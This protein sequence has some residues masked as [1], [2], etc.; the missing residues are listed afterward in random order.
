[1]KADIERLDGCQ[2]VLDIEVDA[3][4]MGEGLKAA[5]RRV[6]AKA[7]VPGFRKGKAPPAMVEHYFG[8][9]ALVQDAVEHMVPGLYEKAVAEHQ[10]DAIDQPQVDILYSNLQK[11]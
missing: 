5:Y 4:E 10:V 1:M 8:R 2:V 6:G 7:I 3:E 11:N 9:E